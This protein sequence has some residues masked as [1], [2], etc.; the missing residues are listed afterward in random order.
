MDYHLERSLRIKTEERSRGCPWAIVEVEEND[1]DLEGEYSPWVW[2]RYFSGVELTYSTDRSI[3]GE[4]L[5]L[6]AEERLESLER[7]NRSI[8]GMPLWK[9]ARYEYAE[10]ESISI[11]LRPG[12]LGEENDWLRES[13]SFFGT[14][15]QIE[16]FFLTVVPIDD[17]EEKER[18]SVVGSPSFTSEGPDFLEETL[19]D[20]LHFYW[21]LDRKHFSSIAERTLNG[22]IDQFVFSIGNVPGF[23]AEWSPT[24]FA[25]TGIKVLGAGT[26]QGFDNASTID[27]EP[28]RLGLAGRADMSCRRKIDLGFLDAEKV[29]EVEE[30]DTDCAE[31]FSEVPTRTSD[32]HHLNTLTSA[33]RG[34]WIAAALAAIA[35]ALL[36]F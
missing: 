9:Q 34:A 6:G 19:P 32:R 14:K 15:R 5:G 17:P 22:S 33:E 35:V 16:D 8:D 26:E 30:Q 27:L 1:Q 28:P 20:S 25:E 31:T 10:R 29:T 12:R 11:K 7:F 13:Y 18:C 24:I 21:F 2:T 4:N 23:Y 36:I 3:E